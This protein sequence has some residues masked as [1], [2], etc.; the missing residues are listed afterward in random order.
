MNHV[1][2]VKFNIYKGLNSH[3][4]GETSSDH[5]TQEECSVC[6]WDVGHGEEE[7]RALGK[8]RRKTQCKEG[9]VLENLDG[10]SCPVGSHD[11]ICFH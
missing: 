9:E 7:R 2:R 5:S 3:Y 1:R 8:E 4:S 11:F 6:R 10:D